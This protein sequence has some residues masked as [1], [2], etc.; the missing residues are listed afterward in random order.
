MLS[1]ALLSGLGNVLFALFFLVG[2]YLY[3][4]LIRQIRARSWPPLEPEPARTFGIPEVV[5][6]LLLIC[7]FLTNI[8]GANTAHSSILTPR[9][10]VLNIVI[11]VVMVL[12]LAGFLQL[13]GF[14]LDKLGGLSNF[15][16]ARVVA[17]GVLLLV[18]AYPL[19]AAADAIT[20]QFLN[21][22]SSRQN[23]VELFNG[24]RT[25]EQRMLIIVLAVAIAPMAEEFVFRFF[26]YGVLRRYVGRFGALVFTAL[27]FAAVHAH[28]PSFAPLFVLGT[29]FTLAYEW[30]GSI[31]VSMT[32][33]S[34]FN[35]VT[36]IFLAF[37]E[38]SQ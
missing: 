16:I 22:G 8:I 28:L 21:N 34:L 37:P 30:S 33:H 36:L 5:V 13:R 25:M 14:D 9:D 3:T 32:M 4:A 17:T 6:A 1:G 27:L 20:R 26:L 38:L 10:I 19:I 31:L 7:L 11:T 15:G 2:I 18:A 29:C 23:I 12:I 35:S 24:S